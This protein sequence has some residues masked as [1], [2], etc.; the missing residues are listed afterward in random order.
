MKT[1]TVLILA[2]VL[3]AS[4]S[5]AL[6]HPA[7][8]TPLTAIALFGAATLADR[9]LAVAM[10]LLCLAVSDLCLEGTHRLGL[11]PTWGFYKGMWTVYV[12][13]LAITALGFLLRQR[14]DG[15]TIAGVT[16]AGSIT[17][18][19]LS[20]FAVWALG[21]GTTYPHT[22]AGLAACYA[23]AIPFFHTAA[24]P[25]GFLGNQLLGDAFYATALFGGLAL[26]ERWW[27]ALAMATPGDEPA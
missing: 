21:E 5:R 23:A 4:L 27:P 13:M 2:A 15:V 6:P 20:N 7:N 26:A 18:F 10:P 16:L 11:M 17:F 1:R 19:V 3:V 9:R 8:F 25:F 24:P 14:R 22:L 12:S